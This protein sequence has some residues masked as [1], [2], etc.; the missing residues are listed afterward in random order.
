MICWQLQTVSW[1]RSIFMGYDRQSL[2]IDVE[3]K[4]VEVKQMIFK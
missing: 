3:S 2:H 1:F 4:N